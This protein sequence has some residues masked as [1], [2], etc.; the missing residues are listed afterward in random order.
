M[1]WT[2]LSLNVDKNGHLLI[3]S[4]P[5][6]LIHVVIERP[7]RPAIPLDLVSMM[8]ELDPGQRPQ[9][10]HVMAHPWLAPHLYRLPT[11]LGSLPCTSKAARRPLSSVRFNPFE[12]IHLLTSSPR[13][14]EN[15]AKRNPVS[16]ALVF[17]FHILRK[18]AF[19]NYVD[20]MRGKGSKNGKILST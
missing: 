17:M 14:L 1:P 19:N 20:K 16:S 7:H 9:L 12:S 6:H 2:F 5:P 11:T 8:L 10:A 15:G 18:G 4:Y 3:H 13:S